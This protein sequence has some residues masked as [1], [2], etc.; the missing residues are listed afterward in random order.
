MVFCCFSVYIHFWFLLLFIYFSQATI[1][2]CFFTKNEAQ[3]KELLLHLF[4]DF[5]LE[6]RNKTKHKHTDLKNIGKSPKTYT[7][8]QFKSCSIEDK[9]HTGPVI[10]LIKP[11][12]Q[13]KE[14]FS[15][16]NMRACLQVCVYLNCQNISH[17]SLFQP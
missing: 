2:N 8:W 9:Y 16:G 10:L 12:I 5:Y 7:V 6:S 1:F 17:L 11:F 15:L 14:I 4:H 3:K 13:Y